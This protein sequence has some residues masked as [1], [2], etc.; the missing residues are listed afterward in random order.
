MAENTTKKTTAQAKSS[1]TKAAKKAT[2]QAPKGAKDAANTVIGLGVLGVNKVQSSMR[3]IMKTVK[4]D[5]MQGRLNKVVEQAADAA[6]NTSKST[7]KVVAR[8]DE[9]IEAAINRFEASFEQ[10]EDKLPAQARDLSKKAR[11]T[12]RKTR[13]Q[14]RQRVLSAN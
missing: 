11:E 5:E 10:Y 7:T 8:A 12:G 14:V 4:A 3:D 9:S 13:E 6:R 1:A 2:E